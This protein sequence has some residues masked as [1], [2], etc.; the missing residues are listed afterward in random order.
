LE[1]RS[2]KRARTNNKEI[3]YR[4]I[5]RRK[6]FVQLFLPSEESMNMKGKLAYGNEEKNKEINFV[7]SRSSVEHVQLT[8]WTFFNPCTICLHAASHSNLRIVLGDNAIISIQLS[9]FST[10]HLLLFFVDEFLMCTMHIYAFSRIFRMIFRYE[11]TSFNNNM[12]EMLFLWVVFDAFKF[13]W[14]WKVSNNASFFCRTPKYK[15]N[16]RRIGIFMNP[17]QFLCA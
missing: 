7:W 15:K 17:M 1:Q 4:M 14:G 13:D 12:L 16:V 9:F 8:L 6:K 5:K 2:T 11:S 10:A 3:S